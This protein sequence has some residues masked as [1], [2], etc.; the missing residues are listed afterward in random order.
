MT[1]II[2]RFPM[3][4]LTMPSEFPMVVVVLSVAVILT[5]VGLVVLGLLNRVCRAVR[6]RRGGL[7]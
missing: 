4:T 7:R 6:A 5:A 2:G 1:P 3:M